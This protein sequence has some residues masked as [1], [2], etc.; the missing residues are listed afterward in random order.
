MESFGEIE[1]NVRSY[2]R[3]FPAT[4]DTARGAKLYDVHGREYLDFLSACGSL[5]YG[6]NHPS[7]KEALAEHIAR[8]GLTISLDLHSSTKRAF[9]N[10]FD[11]IILKPRELTYR[12]QFPGPTGTNAIEAAIKLARKVT[13]RSAV[14]SFTNGF[15]GCSLG[16]LALTGNKHHRGSS[17]P[18]LSQVIR[19]PYDRYLG[20]NFD[21]AEVLEKYLNDPSSGCHAPA[22]II[23]EAIQG[24]GGLNV[25]SKAWAQRV[26][27][28]AQSHGALLILDEIQSGC[29]RSGT[30]FSF[31]S[32]GIEPDIVCLAKSLSGLGLPMALVL[33]KPEIDL[34]EP[35]EHNGTFRGNN[36]AFVTATRALE[37]FWNDASFQDRQREIAYLT[38]FRLDALARHFGLKTKGRGMM[39]GLEFPNAS[40]AKE[41]QSGCV[42][43]GLIIEVCG[44]HDEVLKLLPPLTIS[45]ADLMKG[46]DIIEAAISAQLAESTPKALDVDQA[47][48]NQK[49]EQLVA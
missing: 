2:C 5:N 17:E 21:T 33:I 13:G 11:H 10:T 25:A 3:T 27:K 29:G 20:D 4:F 22:A 30:F 45:E 24:E 8:D 32:L 23:F 41:V 1:S 26:E 35:G 42:A 14:I 37:L 18:L 31:E 7:L 40:M 34:W 44:P 12:V 16:A 39:V 46:L 48:R 43:R 28:I 6:H 47:Y 9:L 49:A 36:Y 15:H 19:M 38:K